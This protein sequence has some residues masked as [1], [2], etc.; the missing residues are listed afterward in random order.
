MRDPVK[1]PLTESVGS[2]TNRADSSV[3][4]SKSGTERAAGQIDV[5]LHKIERYEPT[6]G[7]VPEKGPNKGR[8]DKRPYILAELPKPGDSAGLCQWLT[9]SLGLDPKHH[10]TRGRRFGT[11]DTDGSAVLDRADAPAL[12]FAPIT[13]L[14]TPGKLLEALGAGMSS[15]DGVAPPLTG[16]HCPYIF[17]AVRWL[18]D[19]ADELTAGERLAAILRTFLAGAEKIDDELTSYATTS[20]QRYDLAR[21]LSP[22]LNQYGKPEGSLRYLVDSNTGELVIRVSDLQSAARAAEGSGLRRGELDT[23]MKEHGWQRIRIDG[24]KNAGRAGRKGPHALLFA[25]RGVLDTDD[26]PDEPDGQAVTT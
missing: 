17:A 9:L 19:C 8:E 25:Y 5:E 12:R 20:A 10:V 23:L 18:C 2:L 14:S 22:V 24:H 21:E 3:N 16:E 15:T 11:H 26:E 7:P 1:S 6:W 4:G 13:R